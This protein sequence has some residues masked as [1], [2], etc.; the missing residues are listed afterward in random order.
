MPHGEA[1]KVR[2]YCLCGQKMKV[3]ESMFGRPGKCV[4]CRQK[5]RI[6]QRDEIPATAGGVYDIF[7]KDH[8]EFL[9]KPSLV[10]ESDE[11]AEGQESPVIEEAVLETEDVPLGEGP[12][13][14]P[15]I[16]LDV[17]EPLRVLCSFEQKVERHLQS[18]R[19]KRMAIVEGLDKAT[20]MSYRAMVR[21]ARSTLDEQLRQRLYEVSEQLSG[22]VEQTARATL[23]VRTGEMDYD[24]FIKSVTPLRHRRE[25]LELRRQNLRG[26]LATTDPAMAGGYIDVKLEDVPV[27]GIEVTFPLDEKTSVPLVDQYIDRLRD[28]LHNR[29]FA[30]RKIAERKRMEQDGTL[31]GVSLGECWEDAE[32]ER[33]RA[34]TAVAFYRARLEQIAQ[35]SENDIRSAK[36]CLELARS[37]L[38]AGEVDPS[39]FQS[40]EMALLR[41]QSDNAQARDLARRA[42]TANTGSDV[43]RAE[44]TFL[45]RIAQANVPSGIGL[46]SWIAWL[47][48]SLMILN[49]AVPISNAQENGNMVVAKEMA[50]GLF[51]TAALLAM[52]AVIPHRE[53]RGLCIT[54]L[55]FTACSLGAFYLQTIWHSLGPVGNA[56]RM[57]P[58]WYL[59]PGMMLFIV[60]MLV[61]GVSAGVGLFPF[62]RLRFVPVAAGAAC[63][64]AVVSIL[65]DG[66][67]I[68]APKPYLA[69]PEIS[70]ALESPAS[71]DVT[72]PIRN[73]G[74]AGR[75]FWLGSE[76]R[77]VPN[78]TAF[79]LERRIGS[80]SWKDM[81][82]PVRFKRNNMPWSSV[83][84]QQ[85][86]QLIQVKAGQQ[87]LLAYRLEPATYRVLV[88]PSGGSAPLVKIFTLAPIEPV[89]PES[90]ALPGESTPDLISDEP[91]NEEGDSI[92]T[93]TPA[94][95]MEHVIL[96]LRGVIN[97]EDRV[98]VFSIILRLPDGQETSRRLTLSEQIYGPW[99][100]VEFSPRHKTLTVS[101]GTQML[102]IKSGE[103][104]ELRIPEEEG[105]KIEEGATA[106]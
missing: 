47:S 71:Y 17:L 99:K 33:E 52:F 29:E 8:P 63:F 9:R 77:N 92:E 45:R 40:Q 81:G 13:Q 100:A 57:D 62:K 5:I 24:T 27:D 58:D 88:F 36:A 102:M 39:S 31:S 86:F 44:G 48:M 65:T 25:R 90:T 50:I 73:Q 97:A 84:H 83:G 80:D 4:A 16:P 94:E 96:E 101:D 41:S 59:R 35:D 68:F 23:A 10:Q 11:A 95:R 67:G 72:I 15:S 105:E 87:V 69:E 61:M 37:R 30:E 74:W 93:P 79:L 49:I 19:K 55:W 2:I 20:L 98:P 51:V 82:V 3:S 76:P 89:E 14:T 34:R 85:D 56:M 70:T 28:A 60:A 64:C 43:P 53:Y 66:G 21:N 32:A 42:L 106:L 91:E 38:D 6:P 1:V 54:G 18:V 12:D 78:M 7:L 75:S 104:L 26:W 22:V 103:R 46:D